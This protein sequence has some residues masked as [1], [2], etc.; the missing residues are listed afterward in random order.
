[1]SEKKKALTMQ[2][3]NFETSNHSNNSHAQRQR[4][5]NYLA[6]H[7]RATTLE[8]RSK[9]DVLHPSGR[10]KELRQHNWQIDTLWEDHPT[11]CGKLHRV[12]V[13]VLIRQPK[14]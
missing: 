13:Y 11:D 4:I 12:G 10:I 9:L 6:A 5:A 7:G 3:V 14:V 2:G 8:L 1:M